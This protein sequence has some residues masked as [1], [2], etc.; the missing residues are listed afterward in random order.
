MQAKSKHLLVTLA[1]RDFLDQAKQLFSSVYHNAGWRGDYLLLAHDV[2]EADL[3]WFRN[4]GI[5]IYDCPPLDQ[6]MIAND[7][8]PAVVLAKFYLFT[9]YFRQWERIVFLDADIIVRAS[10]DKLLTTTGLMAV[11]DMFNGRLKRQFE[12]SA[13]PR[14]FDELSRQYDLRDIA[15]NSG[16]LVFGPEII[17]DGLFL[18]LINLYKK[19]GI[20]DTYGEQGIFNLAFYH[21]WRPLP[22][23]YNFT[24]YDCDRYWIKRGRLRSINIHFIGPEKP[25]RPNNVFYPLWRENLAL[26]E[27]IDL[28][29]PL[30][31]KQTWSG[32]QIFSY[33]LWLRSLRI[34][35]AGLTLI[36]E[37]LHRCLGLSGQAIKKKNPGLYSQMVKLK[38]CFPIKIKHQ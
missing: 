13:D 4:K 5:L 9:S 7:S 34:P 16:V 8:L 17:T 26:A 2:P 25:W 1:D 33:P 30:P 36:N 20:L 38:T 19:F 11:T 35:R 37:R 21:N 14:L 18:Q 29:H 24:L 15:F 27:N 32:W 10:L 23:V 12:S 3:A 31:A 22:V 28:A 6:G